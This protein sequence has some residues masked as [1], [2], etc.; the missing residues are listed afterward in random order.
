MKLKNLNLLNFLNSKWVCVKREKTY[1]YFDNPVN[2]WNNKVESY[3]KLKYEFPE[4]VLIIKFEELVKNPADI[5]CFIG[6]LKNIQFD[7]KNFK[8]FKVY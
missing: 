5:I 1:S 2:L 4:R 3:F 7:K 8:Y 6:K